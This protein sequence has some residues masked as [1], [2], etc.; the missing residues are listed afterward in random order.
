MLVE[1]DK[2]RMLWETANDEKTLTMA[3][4][5]QKRKRN[6]SRLMPFWGDYLGMEWGAGIRHDFLAN[7]TKAKAMQTNKRNGVK[8][9]LMAK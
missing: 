4:A 6:F 7:Q 2:H 1:I 9:N 8:Q 5:L 3:N